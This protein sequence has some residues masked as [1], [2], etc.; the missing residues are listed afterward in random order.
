MFSKGVQMYVTRIPWIV[1]LGGWV[2]LAG[3]Q[4]P[5][6]YEQTPPT[7]VTVATPVVKTVPIYLEENGQTEAVEEALVRARV[8]GIIEQIPEESEESLTVKKGEQLFLIQQDEFIAAVNS[9]K[10]SVAA[11]SASLQTAEAK[12][13]VAEAGIKTADAAFGVSDSEFKRL[14]L[15]FKQNAIARSELDTASADLE[16]ARAGVDAAKAEAISANAGVSEAKAALDKAKADLAQ[17]ELELSWTQVE[18]PINGRVTRTMVKIGNLVQNGDPL[19][20]I[21]SA[22]KVWANFNIS[23]RFLLNLE[24]ETDKNKNE[25]GGRNFKP[26]TIPVSLKRNGD[27][28]FIFH[29]FMDYADPVVDQDTGTLLLRAIFDNS[30]PDKFLLPGLFVRVRVEIGTYDNALLIPEKAV[31]R[32]SAGAYVYVVNQ[33]SKA[34]RKNIV[35]GGKYDDMIVVE[36]GLEKTDRVVIDGI[37]MLRPGSEVEATE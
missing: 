19:I 27:P 14:D 5:V 13:K 32:D 15:L 2:C 25:E 23:E 29:G 18:A 28:G 3:C 9:A 31:N 8:R 12:V 17:K 4:K 21:V 7:Q 16:T 10:A 24:R 33:E 34:D 26:N 30:D 11:A 6:S 1:C 36:S 20:Q 35:L 37:Q 22:D